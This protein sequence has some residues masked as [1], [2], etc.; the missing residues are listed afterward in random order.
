MAARKRAK[1]VRKS[2]V[3]INCAMEELPHRTVTGEVT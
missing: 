2:I 3:V 1:S